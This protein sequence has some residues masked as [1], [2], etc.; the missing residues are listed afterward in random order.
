M[1]ISGVEDEYQLASDKPKLIYLKLPAPE[2]EPALQ[3]LVDRIR[4]EE[5]TSYK[6]FSTAEELGILLR[7]PNLEPG[8]R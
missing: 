3:R 2:R 4:T 6:K 5:V 7:K 1:Q 8:S